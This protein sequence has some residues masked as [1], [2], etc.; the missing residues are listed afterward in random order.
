MFL[1]LL[2]IYF[3]HFWVGPTFTKKP[4]LGQAEMPRVLT[5]GTSHVNKVKNSPEDATNDKNHSEEVEVVPESTLVSFW[6]T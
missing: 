2:F 5:A 6:I 1:Q 4:E 3:F